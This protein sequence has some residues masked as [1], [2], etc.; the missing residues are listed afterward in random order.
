MENKWKSIW[1]SRRIDESLIGSAD[2]DSL[3]LE[4]KRCNG[5]DVLDG[6]IPLESLKLQ[7]AV[8]RDKLLQ[9]APKARSVYEVGC[10]SG[11]NLLLFEKDGWTTGGLDYSGALVDIAR[12]VL[13][14]ED[15]SCAEAGAV[16]EEP[17]YDCLLSNSV[18]SYFPNYDYAEGVLEKM[19]R[20]A[21]YALTLIDI[22]DSK[23]K[24]GFIAYRKAEIA[25]YEERYRGLPKLFYDKAFFESFARRRGLHIEF[26]DCDMK[27]YW[28][29]RFV[30][31]TVMYR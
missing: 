14:S 25:D 18:F 15:L 27:G 30:F 11:A 10:G 7:Y 1:E 9:Y 28:N 2:T 23:K 16:S 24:D 8:T 21:R 4:L 3:F 20:K 6:G 12:R 29:N 17:Q 31:H 13:K 22:H 5:F 26:F 19:C